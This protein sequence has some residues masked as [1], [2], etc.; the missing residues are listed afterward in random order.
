MD[1]SNRV[2]DRNRRYLH[3]FK[4]DVPTIRCPST[5]VQQEDLTP[6]EAPS[7]EHFDDHQAPPLVDSCEVTTT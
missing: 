3:F 7:E 2:T 5:A 6:G 4:P 1:G